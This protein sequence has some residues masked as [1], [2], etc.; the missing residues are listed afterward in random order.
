MSETIWKITKRF[1]F[2]GGKEN[3]IEKEGGEE[4]EALKK[5]YYQFK[6]KKKKLFYYNFLH[7]AGETIYI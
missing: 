3:G 6:K 4:I 7:K 5:I 1:W 2:I